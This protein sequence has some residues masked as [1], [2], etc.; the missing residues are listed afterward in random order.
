MLKLL[1]IRA[2]RLVSQDGERLARFYAGIG[3]TICSVQNI[4]AEDMA[5]L[6]LEGGGM[7][8]SLSLGEQR[9]EID[10]YER[11]GAPYPESAD[12]AA[13]CFQHFAIVT[14]RI[15]EDWRRAISFGATQI[16]SGGPV[17]LPASSGGV[18]AGKFRD[19]DG[20]PLE[21]LAFPEP[22]EHGWNGEGTLGIDHSAISVIDL[23][24]TM[25]FFEDRGLIRH[26]GSHNYGP[27]Q[28]SLDGLRGADAEVRPLA[29][30]SA[31]PHLELL[32]YNRSSA[33]D[34]F[35]GSAND[36]ASTRIVWKA[37]GESEPFRDPSGHWHEIVR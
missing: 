31:P 10:E 27:E 1:A 13:P 37:D 4:P 32:A 6:G 34:P 26:K 18:T 33:G 8:W 25:R 19:P 17:R 11:S 3:F 15:A 24:K 22:A 23:A 36:V 14:T 16:S 5:R 2:I 35:H 21:L 20:H 9:V 28:D 12:A 7:R 30:A 29:P